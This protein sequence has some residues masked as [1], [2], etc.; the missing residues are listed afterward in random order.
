M[1][2]SL[3]RDACAFASAPI[4]GSAKSFARTLMARIDKSNRVEAMLS[5]NRGAFVLVSLLESG[6]KCTTLAAELKALTPQLG[7]DDL[8]P[9]VR[10]MLKVCVCREAGGGN[11]LDEVLLS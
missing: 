5:C 11:R 6:E 7:E 10:L 4:S 2:G 9:G 1:I 8:T 3:M